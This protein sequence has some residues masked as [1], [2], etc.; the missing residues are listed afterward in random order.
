ME[1]RPREIEQKWQAAWRAAGLFRPERRPDRPKKYVLEMFPY[2]SGSFHM[3]HMRNYTIG[4]VLARYFWMTGHA[5]LHPMG[6]DA[7]GLPAENAAIKHQIHPREWTENNI[8][9]IKKQMEMM[10]FSYDWDR[11]ISTCDPSYYRWTQWIFLQ[12]YHRGLAYRAQAWVNW[13]PNC[14]TV[15]ANEQVIGGKCWRCEAQVVLR[16]LKQWFLRITAY[17]EDLLKGLED[18]Q[19]WPEKVRIM[20]KNWIGRSEGVELRFQLEN[21]KPLPIFTT[22]ADTLFGVTFVGISTFHP[23]LETLL[24]GAPHLQEVLSFRER[25]PEREHGNMEGVDTGLHARHPFTGEWVPVWVADYILHEYGTGAVMGV[26]A[27]DTRDYDFAQKHGLPVRPVVYPPGEEMCPVPYTEYG[28]L[29]DSGPFTGLS[30]EEAQKAI[31][32]AAEEKNLGGPRVQYRLRDWLI[33]RQRYWGCPIPILYCEKCGIQPVPEKDLPVLLPPDI[34]FTGRGNPLE[35]AQDFVRTRCPKCGGSARRETDTMDTFV[36]SSWYFLRYPDP[37]NSEKPASLEVLR[38]WMPV[39]HYIGGI[40]H[41]ILHLLYSRFFTRFLHDLGLSPVRE[42]FRHLFTQGM[43][44]L[45]GVAMSKSRGNIVEP[46]RMAEQY[47][48]DTARLYVLFAAPPEKNMEWDDSAV[49]GPHRFLVRLWNLVQAEKDLFPAPESPVPSTEKGEALLRATHRLMEGVRKD[50]E[51]FRLNTAIAKMMEFLNQAETY[52]RDPGREDAVLAF[53]LETL[54]RLLHPFAPHITE[55]LWHQM[56]HE[57][58][59]LDTPYPRPEDRWLQVQTVRYPVQ[60]NGKIRDELEVPADLSREEILALAKSRD[61]VRK[62]LEGAQ[63]LREIV[64]P[65]RIISFQIRR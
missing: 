53:A 36:D 12:M 5:V 25:A 21:G 37:R 60:I 7:F 14:E 56:R 26:P 40:E 50:M 9:T 34:R 46:E 30:S 38:T 29:K 45:G 23:E 42:P 16:R 62:Y 43:V 64:V 41:A 31:A 22:R 35:Q 52:A 65:G 10:G 44:T 57:D 24:E 55:E 27:H 4:D 2:P 11:E 3:G 47:G 28:V 13:C 51:R 33:S 49:A 17:A 1:Y 6:W 15:L 8:A 19:E 39:D 18:L 63:I 61:R 48:V 54:V 32:R 20:Q 59:L 58:F